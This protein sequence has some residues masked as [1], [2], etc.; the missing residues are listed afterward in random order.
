MAA[1]V[2]PLSYRVSW[3]RARPASG[4]D[5]GR[6]IL[7]PRPIG[8]P[9]DGLGPEP[10]A[11]AKPCA[12]ALALAC[13]ATVAVVLPNRSALEHARNE[14]TRRLGAVDPAR[15]YTVLGLARRVLGLDAS[16]PRLATP[17]E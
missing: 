5:M 14:V 9:P 2:R 1:D 11:S 15:F 7:L 16:V 3:E 17:R 12:P 13:D 4:A 10:F 8:G 6:R